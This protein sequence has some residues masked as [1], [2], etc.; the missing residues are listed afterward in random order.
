MNKEQIDQIITSF[1]EELRPL[2]LIS[3]ELLDKEKKELELKSFSI[4]ENGV[5]LEN[6][7][8]A[9]MIDHT[10]L[11][12]NASKADIEK[13]CS[14]AAKYNFMS[15]CVNPCN[16][17]LCCEYLKLSNVKICTVIDFPLGS[18]YQDANIY[19]AECALKNGA[20]ELDMVINTGRLKDKDYAYVYNDIKNLAGCKS[21]NGSF[22]LKVIIETCLLTDEEKIKACM[23]SKLA[24]AGYVKTSTGFST[25]GADY[26]DIA[27][28]RYVVGGSLGVKASGGVK[29]REKAELMAANGASRIGTSSGIEILSGG[30]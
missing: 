5:P 9:R 28:M 2:N 19:E 3:N 15:V 8:L 23:L 12:P 24:K 18:N 14:E 16:V 29:T 22:L 26:K 20:S 21:A 30:N 17:T 1:I 10:I 11:K 27:L 4:K 13:L 25:A 6:N 7:Y